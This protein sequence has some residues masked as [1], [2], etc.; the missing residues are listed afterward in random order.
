MIQGRNH[1]VVAVPLGLCETGNRDATRQLRIFVFVLNATCG[2]Y[3]RV[4][5]QSCPSSFVSVVGA[6]VQRKCSQAKPGVT[7]PP[8]GQGKSTAAKSTTACMAYA[9][10]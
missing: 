10:G 1:R 9:Q 6:T 7:R 5:A 3:H 8:Q 2:P 4:F